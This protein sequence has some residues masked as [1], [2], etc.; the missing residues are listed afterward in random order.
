M[1]KINKLQTFPTERLEIHITQIHITVRNDMANFVENWTL[2]FLKK[3]KSNLDLLKCII[4]CLQGVA[5]DV[6][7]I[8]C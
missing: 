7:S 4:T 6:I 3:K 2:D 5:N 8:C 1:I